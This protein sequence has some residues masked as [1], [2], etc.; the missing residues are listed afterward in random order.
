M[1]TWEEHI[2]IRED[3]ISEGHAKGL[4]EGH[5]KGLVDGHMD[6]IRNLMKSMGLTASQAMDAIGIPQSEQH[7]YAGLLDETENR[8]LSCY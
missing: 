3:G 7:L 6:A 2:M 1:N 5:A 4:S 8:P